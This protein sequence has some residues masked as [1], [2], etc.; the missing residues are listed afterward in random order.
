VAG[1]PSKVTVGVD[2][3]SFAVKLS[4]TMFANFARVAL[5]MLLAMVTK[6]RLG[7]VLSTVTLLLFVVDVTVRSPLPAR[8]HALIENVT[9]PSAVSALTVAVAVQLLP[10]GLVTVAV[11]S[12]K[13]TIGVCIASFA[14]KL[15]V[16]IRS[17]PAS[18]TLSSTQRARLT[19]W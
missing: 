2:I 16:T 9:L 12:N 10:L 19:A 6:L 1:T 18:Q 5:V 4:V 17:T 14:V 13:V 11:T 8:S 7:N 3:V 15:S